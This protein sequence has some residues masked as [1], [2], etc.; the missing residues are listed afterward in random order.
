MPTDLDDIFGSLGRQADAIP[1]GTAE[2]ARRRGRQRS[3]N[4][5][6]IAAGAAVCLVLAG[7]G[8]MVRP[9]RHADHPV[10]P[11]P[12]AG[13][14]PVVGSPIEFDPPVRESSAPDVAGG[15]VYTAW[16]AG[17]GKVTVAGADLHTGRLDWK[18]TGMGLDD[19]IVSYG[20]RAAEQGIM[21]AVNDQIYVYDPAH[22]NANDWV[23]TAGDLDEVV[24]FD[25]AL[26]RRWDI[27]GQIDAHN[28]RTG[29]KLW[30]LEPQA[31]KA[32]RLIG[33]RAPSD[34]LTADSHSDGRMLAVTSSGKIQVRDA[35]SGQ[36]QRTI[37]PAS[38][39][40][41][42]SMFVAY[43][44]WLYEGGP[45][46]CDSS[47]YRVV[48]TNLATG[49]S[50]VVLTEGVGHALGGLDVCGPGRVCVL[51]QKDG[52]TSVSA[53]D[54]RQRKKVWTVA[55]PPDGSSL[56]SYNGTMLIG[57][58][59]NVVLLDA[60][61]D[62]LLSTPATHVD[63]L[64]PNRLLVMPITGAGTVSVFDITTRKLTELGSVPQRITMCAHS[65][66]RLACPTT[67]DLRIY[68][69]TG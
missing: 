53:V 58:G 44:G 41:A 12:S 65:A 57:G 19:E 5:A 30:T 6:L 25:Q 31:D 54:V 36:L 18:V 67:T 20:V 52:G 1:L 16:K 17:D 68:S 59:Q 60:K 24:P 14:L 32:V 11:A 48:A 46:C 45:P 69:L 61:G 34:G 4:G 13:P 63:W 47:A 51:D 2:Q 35:A 28:W 62:E 22:E 37:T 50:S 27:N 49:E 56:S 8:V 64:D 39:A 15:K 7:V 66:D 40:Q 3:R 42:G 43:D 33:V 10:T 21:V 38:P 55:G 29:R 26:I 9:Q 23:L